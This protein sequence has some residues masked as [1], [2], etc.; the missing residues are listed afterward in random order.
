MKLANLNPITWIR[1]KSATK[2]ASSDHTKSSQLPKLPEPK[3]LAELVE[4]MR[5][6]YQV[7]FCE[8]ILAANIAAVT[9][10]ISSEN[11]S[12]KPL[13]DALQ[14]LWDKTTSKMLD[15]IAYGRVAFEATWEKL[16]SGQQCIRKL[17]DLPFRLSR[18]KLDEGEFVGIEL[19]SQSGWDLLIE[20]CNAWWLAI[21]ATVVNPHGNSRF[22]PAPHN[23][24]KSRAG[25]AKNR[26]HAVSKWALRGPIMRG[27]GQDVDEL[28]GQVYDP[29]AEME[30]GIKNWSEG[31]LLYLPNA[32]ES[33]PD[34]EYKYV[35]EQASLEGFDP[36]ALNA[37]MDRMDVELM[38]AFGIPE[39]TAMEGAGVGTY[40]AVSQM[41]MILYA[42]VEELVKQ[43]V[44]SFQSGV[45]NQVEAVNGLPLN[46]IT[47]AFVRLTSKPD[48]FVFEVLKLLL[49]NPAM[50]EA[51][52]SGGVNLRELLEQ[53]G[54][55]VTPQLE[56][57]LQA[58][59]MRLQ[60]ASG[61]VPGM[62]PGGAPASQAGEFGTLGR[63]QWQNNKKAVMDILND[64][65]TE[66]VSDAVA[67]ELLQSLGMPGDRAD[68]LIA[69]VKDGT[70]DDP[71]LQGPAAMFDMIALAQV[72]IPRQ[73]FKVPQASQVVN[74]G[75]REFDRLWAALL[76]AMEKRA[77]QAT[78][79]TIRMSILDLEAQMQTAG[80]LLGMLS[81][82]QPRVNTYAGGAGEGADKLPMTL[83]DDGYRFPWIGSAV[84]F[85]E[86]Q[87]VVSASDFAKM[88]TADR[89]EVF[90]AAAIDSPKKLRKLQATLA[91]T[92]K[93]GGDL[94][95]F[96]AKIEGELSLSRSQTETLYRTQTKRG[97]V[98]GFEKSMASPVV[99]DEFPAVLFS[100]TPDSRV[101]DDHWDLD[102]V[103][104]LRSDARA[105]KV[106]SNAAKD[107]QCRCAL[108]PLS[109]A[110]AESRGIKSYSE[111][112]ADAR[113]KYA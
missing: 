104:V 80:R 67:R 9:V 99:A 69:D 42:V 76:D 32:R 20:R 102:G 27:P 77:S 41:F 36:N 60:A 74:A 75:L 105:Y 53:V 52:L 4:K 110:E 91:E 38:R 103:V 56:S 92:L 26:E 93:E 48:T 25:V 50:V 40:G 71:E 62:Q 45:I 16:E 46:T 112:P 96:R 95:Q 68:A 21:D 82:W 7:A 97:Y 89:R 113:A 47:A 109:L 84:E 63:R 34:S 85:L 111:L 100:A 101:R 28:T 51:V 78:I 106:L 17:D 88:A 44:E 37:S 23:V 5:G 59:A 39:K 107:W 64:V 79:D 15:A 66:A 87:G 33:G 81:P 29:F 94:R 70:V 90:S 57:L 3:D 12:A 19:K 98:A 86:S 10:T 35:V 83:A 24:W 65:K 2:Q 58:A 49:A 22:I 11:E 61:T 31:N 18:M 13:A 14:D 30:P 108:I 6:D 1:G 55:P 8:T 73:G 72:P 54:L 43:L